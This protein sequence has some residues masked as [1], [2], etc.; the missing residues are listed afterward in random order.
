MK[1]HAIMPVLAYALLGVAAPNVAPAL[2][3]ST[4][5][6][7]GTCG[8]GYYTNVDG[9]CIQRPTEAPSAPAGATAHCRDG[10]YSFSQHRQGT[11][12]HHGGVA[13]WL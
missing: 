10:T 8:A 9:R 4:A 1:L 11:C 12:S 7:R 2:S 3:H 5:E 13:E 6:A